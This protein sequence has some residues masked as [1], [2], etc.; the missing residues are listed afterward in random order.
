MTNGGGGIP[1]NAIGAALFNYAKP[2]G[3]PPAILGSIIQREWVPEGWNTQ[4]IADNQA[5][6][7]LMDAEPLMGKY[8]KA[9]DVLYVCMLWELDVDEYNSPAEFRIRIG[10]PPAP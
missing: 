10:L 6:I 3:P 2:G 5:I 8:I 9:F 1:C 4:D 7:A